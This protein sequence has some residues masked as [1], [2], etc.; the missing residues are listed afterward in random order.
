MLKTAKLAL[1]IETNDGEYRISPQSGI[2]LR[3]RGPRAG[4]DRWEILCEKLKVAV[5]DTEFTAKEAA[6]KFDSS[7]R[8]LQRLLERAI[9]QGKI[10]RLGGSRST[11]YRFK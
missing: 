8:T 11:R 3:V 4:K 10:V 5:G 6:G 1:V 7:S 2:G 9:D